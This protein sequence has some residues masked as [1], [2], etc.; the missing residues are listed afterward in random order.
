MHGETSFEC[1]C[2]PTYSSGV[3]FSR[4]E[5]ILILKFTKSPNG[6]KS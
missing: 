3:A 5:V 6:R 1:A 4:K 2:S